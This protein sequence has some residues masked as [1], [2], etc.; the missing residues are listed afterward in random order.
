MALLGRGAEIFGGARIVLADP[1]AVVERRAHRILGP[2]LA[3]G[4]GFI[5]PLGAGSEV[6]VDPAPGIVGL[7]QLV[8]G[9][10]MAAL[11]GLLE[12]RE[13]LG[14]LALALQLQT[15]SVECVGQGGAGETLEFRR[16][17][18]D[19]RARKRLVGILERVLHVGAAGGRQAD[20]CKGTEGQGDPPRQ[21]PPPRCKL[22]HLASLL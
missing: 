9:R 12:A 15:A 20:E 16:V 22:L 8:G 1:G 3:A 21:R 10:A 18:T 11:G 5:D 14:I 6:L 17:L 2:R 7:A 13:G 19:E 4:G